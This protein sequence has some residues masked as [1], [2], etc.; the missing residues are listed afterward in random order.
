MNRNVFRLVLNRVAGMPV[1]MPAAEVSR[2]RGK[3]G[4]GGVRAQRRGGA[5]CA[6]LLGV[7]GPSLAFAAVVADPNG[8]A[9][10]PGMATTANGTD[11]VNI[12]AP[13]ATGLSHN[14]FNEFSP[15]GRGVVLNNSVRPGESQIG[16]MAAQNPNLMQPATRALLEVTQ[17][18]SVLQGTLEAFGGKL[19]VLVANQHGVTI[20][21]LTTLNVGRL[22]VTTGQVLPQAAGQLRL[23]VTQGDVL[24]DHG[25]IDTQGLDMFDVVSRSIAVRGPIHDSSRAAGADVRLV[26]GATA[27]DPQ[28]GHYEAIAADESKAP[29]QEGISGELLGAM[30]GRHI[31]LVSTESGVGVRHDGPIK[32]AN[33]IRV[34]ANGEVTLGGPQQAA[35]EA[36]AG[37]QAV[38][39]AGMQNVI[40]GGTVSVCARGHVAIQGAVIAGQDVDLQG[41][42]VKAGR[43]SAQRDA[44]VTAADGVTLDGPVDAKRHVWIGAHDDVV[45][46]EAAAEQNVVLLGRSVTAGRLDAQRDVLAAARDGVTIHEAAAA[47]QDVVLQ[48]SSARVGQMSAQRDVLVM[49]ADGVT[50]DGPVSAQRAVWV[51]TQG[52]VAGSEWIKAGRDVQIGAAADLAG[53]VTAEEMQQLKAHGDAANRRRVKAGRNEPAGTA[54]ERPA[55]AAQIARSA[56]STATAGGHAGSFMRVGDGHIAKMTTSREAEIY[57]NYR[58]ALAGV[59]PDTV[60]PEEVDSRVGVTARQRQAMATFKGWA[61]MKGQR[62]VVMQAL[63][64]EIAP[65]DKIELDVKIGA[66]TVS[67]TELIGA[68]R[69]RWQALSKKVRLTAADL[70]RGSR[71]LVGDDRGY[72]LAGRTSGGIA[73]DARNSRNSVGRSSESLIREALDRSPDTRWRN[74]QHLLGQLQT[75]REKMHALPLTFVASS[76]LIAIDKRKPENSVARLIDLAHPVQPFENEA[77]YEKVNHRFEDGLDKLIRLF[78]Q[79]EK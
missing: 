21:G 39:G 45:I 6:A 78:Q 51:E 33:D 54:A 65:E 76:V 7:A 8:G 44:L 37:A 42:S 64:A 35:Q 46:R 70:L 10:R 73:L 18:R 72:T 2:G 15:V 30:H 50:L 17:Q 24:I 62:V 47:G 69:T 13:D 49:A 77:D 71:S 79:V 12:V 14:K 66:S 5:A 58:L 55:A 27:Y 48:G 41:K 60:P 75:I 57:E 20:N 3:L 25:G 28:T 1:P 19:D 67:R 63:G 4:C 40:A 53:A 32:S 52:D 74:A 26:A 34:S 22:G 59:I 56:R 38:G 9:Q 68:G 16:G 11:L 31:V 36:V 23:G 61:E 29:V 43:M